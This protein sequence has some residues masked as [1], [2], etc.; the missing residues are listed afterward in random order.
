MTMTTLSNI[1]SR[2]NLLTVAGVAGCAF[3]GYAVY[4]DYKRRH[5]PDYKA[6]IRESKLLFGQSKN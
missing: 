5:A 6:K 4:F 3:I 1:F 2:N